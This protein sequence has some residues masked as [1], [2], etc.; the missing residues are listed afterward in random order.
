MLRYGIPVRK[1]IKKKKSGRP[2]ASPFC[3]ASI[4]NPKLRSIRLTVPRLETPH[5][6]ARLINSVA[7]SAYLT[8]T[9]VI[10]RDGAAGIMGGK[11]WLDSRIKHTPPLTLSH[12]L[13]RS[14]PLPPLSLALSARDNFTKF[15]ADKGPRQTTARLRVR[16]GGICSHRTRLISAN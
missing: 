2:C 3:G 7:A 10:A 15:S 14:P 16:P 9:C 5:L 13:F 8:A 4:I 11:L 12:S 1:L 6:P